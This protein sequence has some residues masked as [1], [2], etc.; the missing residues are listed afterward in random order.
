MASTSDAASTKA[1]EISAPASS[2]APAPA[3]AR[4]DTTVSNAPTGTAAD[5][6]VHRTAM[7]VG[8]SIAFRL[9]DNPTTGYSWYLQRP[10]VDG[11]SPGFFKPDELATY[12]SPV[13]RFANRVFERSPGGRGQGVGGETV[14]V[15][16]IIAVG[17]ESL[18]FVRIRPWEADNVVNRFD[19]EV[20]GF[21]E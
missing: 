4:A 3:P 8:S 14:F 15:F 5:D 12:S 7:H 13:L 17:H 2:P 1:P 19:A 18:S 21:T 16:D 10:G 20:I 6:S 9:K 11:G